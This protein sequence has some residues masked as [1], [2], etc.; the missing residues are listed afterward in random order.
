MKNTKLKWILVGILV[1]VI[2][3][4][5]SA[6]VLTINAYREEDLGRNPSDQNATWTDVRDGVGT[7]NTLLGAANSFSFGNW[8]SAT[9]PYTGW[10]YNYRDAVSFDTTAIPNNAEIT[11][12]NITFWYRQ[13]TTT[14]GSPNL[15]LIDYSGSNHTNFQNDDYQATTFTR[16]APDLL[17]SD[18]DTVNESVVFVLNAAGLAAIN[19]EGYTSFLTT[20]TN[21]ADDTEFSWVSNKQAIIQ[22]RSHLYS[23]TDLPTKLMIEYTPNTTMNTYPIPLIN[24]TRILPNTDTNLPSSGYNISISGTRDEFESA[25][26]VI[27]PSDATTDVSITSTELTDADGTGHSAIPINATDINLVKAWYQ[28]NENMEGV[29]WYIEDGDTTYVIT[30]RYILTPELLLK[31][32]SIVD[33]NYATQQNQIWVKNATFEGYVH[34]DNTTIGGWLDDWKVYDNATVGGFPVPF[35]IPSDHNKQVWLTTHIPASQQSGN[36]TGKIWVNSSDTDAIAMNYTVRVLPF[37]LQDSTKEHALYY[38][39]VIARSDNIPSPYKLTH[40]IKT[41][42]NYAIELAD[43]RDHG[44]KYPTQMGYLGW[45]AADTAQSTMLDLRIAA[46]LPVD[47][48][49]TTEESLIPYDPDIRLSSTQSDLD[50]LS[51]LISEFNGIKNAKGV[52]DVWVMGYDEP[53]AVQVPSMTSTLTTSIDNGTKTWY[54]CSINGRCT[55]NADVTSMINLPYFYNTTD[56]NLYRV[57][58]PDI[59]VFKYANPQAGVENPEINRQNYGF[60]LWLSAFDGAMTYAYQQTFGQAIWNDFDNGDGNFRDHVFAYP[61]TDGVIDT[62]QWEGY[63]EGV[64]DGRYA[65]T[66]SNITGNTTEATDIINAGITAGDDMSVIRA[67]IIDHILDAM[68]EPPVANFTATPLTGNITTTIQ[69]TDTSNYTPTSWNWAYKN[70]TGNWTNFS[71]SQNPSGNFINPGI[72]SINLTATN[73]NGADDEVKVNYINI[74]ALPPV[75]GFTANATSGV[76]PLTVAFTDTTTNVPTNWSWYVWGNETVS[77]NLQNPT[78]TFTT[79]EHDIRLYAN[80]TGGGSWYNQT[81]YI[82]VYKTSAA[83]AAAPYNTGPPGWLYGAI[84]IGGLLPMIFGLGLITGFLGSPRPDVT[85]M[86]TGA[87]AI[88]AGTL[89]LAIAVMFMTVLAGALGA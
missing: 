86:T 76:T 26:F 71:T 52:G 13:K 38:R 36:Y 30:M 46:G 74:T 62:I 15:S 6:D 22:M 79:G 84:A 75:A 2:V 54:A 65:D 56:A 24:Q 49:Y 7:T 51:S 37:T 72:Y 21:D 88:I 32:D 31:N 68:T 59:K 83:S 9:A 85:Q 45:A 28:A 61:K 33:V 87:V 42:E 20:C 77:S 14:L 1:L 60:R 73:A 43:M 67:H 4:G 48:I 12:A 41:P 82:K 17:N 78:F 80:N 81:D 66:L 19:K 58:N 5:V 29:D 34:I 25:S 40:Y 35:A 23:P 16:L 39:G 69:F 11:S 3:Q 63:R 8:R 27:K 18:M 70:S 50:T 47:H 10:D 64:D 44:I 53:S 89:V 57:I 55:P